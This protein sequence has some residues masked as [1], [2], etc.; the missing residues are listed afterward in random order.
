MNLLEP[1]SVESSQCLGKANEDIPE[2]L[3]WFFF[4]FLAF[5]ILQTSRATRFIQICTEAKPRTTDIIIY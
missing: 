3:R 2:V 4:I 5:D 1:R